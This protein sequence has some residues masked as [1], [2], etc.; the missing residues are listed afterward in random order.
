MKKKKKGMLFL[1]NIKQNHVPYEKKSGT[2][3][4]QR[5]NINTNN[6]NKNKGGGTLFEIAMKETE[7][8]GKLKNI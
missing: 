5:W 2:Q 4:A 6:K 7:E 1:L 3:L 8:E